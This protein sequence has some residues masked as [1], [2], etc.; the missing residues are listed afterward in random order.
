VC[1]W[2]S[3]GINKDSS[4]H[5]LTVYIRIW[6]DMKKYAF[7]VNNI[8]GSQHVKNKLMPTK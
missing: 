2:V 4:Y 1:I 6:N 7:C 8:D 3:K 5:D